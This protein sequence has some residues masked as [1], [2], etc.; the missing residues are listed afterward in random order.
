MHTL[1]RAWPI[2]VQVRQRNEKREFKEW[3]KALRST[4][5]AKMHMGQQST[6]AMDLVARIN[7]APAAQEQHMNLMQVGVSVTGSKKNKFLCV[8]PR[9]GPAWAWQ[10][11][12]PANVPYICTQSPNT[13]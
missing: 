7:R 9:A 3:L 1:N 5:L 11:Q 6:P 8:S 10:L 12:R 2:L 13:N 4:A